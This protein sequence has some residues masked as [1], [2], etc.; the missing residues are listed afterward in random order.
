M[1]SDL[2]KN[3]ILAD[4]IV[5]V[6]MP[7]YNQGEF[8]GGAIAAVLAQDIALELIIVD[9]ASTDDSVARIN[10]AIAGRPNAMLFEPGKIGSVQA[11]N[12]GLSKAR[13]RYV[14]FFAPDDL[15]YPDLLRRSVAL[16]ERTPLANL[17]F[18]EV[19]LVYE[20][21]GWAS[22][23]PARLAEEETYFSPAQLIRYGR[24]KQFLVY[25]ASS[26]WRT[27]RLRALGGWYEGMGWATD[28]FQS[29]GEALRNGVCYIPEAL[30]AVRVGSSSFSSRGRRD[31]VQMRRIFGLVL[32]EL[33]TRQHTD[34]ARRF[35]DACVLLSLGPLF[36]KVASERKFSLTV[37]SP[38]Y[39]LR[40]SRMA[41]RQRF[42][43][44][45]PLSVRR[46]IVQLRGAR[47]SS[48]S[49]ALQRR[50]D[51]QSGIHHA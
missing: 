48:A 25:G 4:C 27:E 47:I 13:G 24:R 16:L 37:W 20:S 18:A 26:V 46:W 17:S 28:W 41:L 2:P 30:V 8:I 42:S 15:I 11:S 43:G 12:F 14:C 23:T 31:P 51:Q 40:V 21:E 34:V 39:F 7:N 33:T 5:S 38:S 9:D 44:D 49:S 35:V 32:D 22:H 19:K 3:P 10:E 6:V 50:K 29:M 1:R 36:M 45:V